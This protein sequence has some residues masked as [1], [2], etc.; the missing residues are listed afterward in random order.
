ME[1]KKTQRL[2]LVI[3][4]KEIFFFIGFRLKKEIETKFTQEPKSFCS[5][6]F[7]NKVFH[8]FFKRIKKHFFVHIESPPFIGI[9]PPERKVL[10]CVNLKTNYNT[11][12]RI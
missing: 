12:I 6:S 1:D 4:E 3:S 9:V 5:I 8:T 2:P 7:K 11:K 10:A